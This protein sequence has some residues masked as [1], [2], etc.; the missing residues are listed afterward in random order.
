MCIFSTLKLSCKK[1]KTSWNSN[2]LYAE[3]LKSQ[4]MFTPN[5]FSRNHF[6]S[7]PFVRPRRKEA[8]PLEE[9]W[10]LRSFTW[11]LLKLKIFVWLSKNHVCVCVRLKRQI[12]STLPQDSL[13]NFVWFLSSSFERIKIKFNFKIFFRNSSHKQTHHQSTLHVEYKTLDPVSYSVNEFKQVRSSSEEKKFHGLEQKNFR[14]C[15]VRLLVLVKKRNESPDVI[16]NAE[17]C[18]KK[19][20]GY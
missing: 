3:T 19:R 15:T 6:C 18:S 2:L 17:S 14:T 4:D 9:G 7:L 16:L 10:G 1:K 20:F 5:A 8:S 11:N 12:L 13:F